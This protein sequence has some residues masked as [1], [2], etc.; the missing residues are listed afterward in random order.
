MSDSDDDNSKK[1]QL[2]KRRFIAGA[3]CPDCAA[4]DTL[5]NYHDKENKYR[6]CVDCG[7][8][9][10]IRFSPRIGEIKTRVNKPFVKEPMPATA[11]VIKF[12]PRAVDKKEE[13]E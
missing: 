2:S 12:V 1:N 4:Q 10:E 9:D 11:Q 7:F 5:V 8:K 3:T 6:E 13:K